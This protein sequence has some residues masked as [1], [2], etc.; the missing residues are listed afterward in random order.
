M[1]F[2]F[3]V[4]MHGNG[5]VKFI[6]GMRKFYLLLLTVFLGESGLC[7]MIND[8]NTDWVKIVIHR[9]DFVTFYLL[10]RTV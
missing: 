1:I 10:C 9:V 7:K 3:V 8:L 5:V 4:R 2:K 6:N